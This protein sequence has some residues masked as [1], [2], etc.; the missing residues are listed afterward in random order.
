[1][2]RCCRVSLCTLC[3]RAR[4][5]SNSI[6]DCRALCSISLTNA[7]SHYCALSLTNALCLSILWFVVVF[8]LIVF[9]SLMMASIGLVN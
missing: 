3:C 4:V 6:V 9:S 7:L 5:H 1:M 8:T 2:I